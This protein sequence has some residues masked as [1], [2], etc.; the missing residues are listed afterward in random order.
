MKNLEMYQKLYH[1]W[2]KY[3]RIKKE[4]M[5]C[6]KCGNK[7]LFTHCEKCWTEIVDHVFIEN[8]EEVFV[9]SFTQNY[10]WDIEWNYCP[11]D[12]SKEE[13]KDKS[14]QWSNHSEHWVFLNYE[15]CKLA[16]ENRPDYEKEKELKYEK[17][18]NK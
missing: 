15:D 9:F 11:V 18:I 16:Y 4:D 17:I 8:I 3:Y 12:F 10:K 7:S 1:I 13:N 2:S 14:W 6:E 5:F